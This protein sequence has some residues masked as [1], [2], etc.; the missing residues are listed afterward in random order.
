M[1]LT[2]AQSS[3]DTL[4]SRTGSDIVDWADSPEK[5]ALVW[6]VGGALLIGVVVLLVKLKMDKD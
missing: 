4:P 6:I 1:L 2:M 5:L 3:T